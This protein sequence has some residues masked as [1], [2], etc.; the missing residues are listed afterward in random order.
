LFFLIYQELTRKAG[1]PLASDICEV[2]KIGN[3][4]E[5]GG[6]LKGNVADKFRPL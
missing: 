1:C 6:S 5:V 4:L 2:P 3:F